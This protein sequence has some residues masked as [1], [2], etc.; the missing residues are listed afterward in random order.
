MIGG[1]SIAILAAGQASRFGGGK[2][3][4][5]LN[6]RPLG[7]WAVD[8]ALALPAGQVEIVVAEPVPLFARQAVSDGV[9]GLILNHRAGDGL[10]TSVALAARRAAEIEANVLLLMLADM[11]LVGTATL[12]RLM[13]EA[14][15]GRPAALRHLSGQAGIPAC[16]TSD[17]FPAL[18]S[19]SGDRGAAALLRDNEATVR[20]DVDPDE[21]QDVDTPADLRRLS[22]RN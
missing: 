13:A 17:F 9:A 6:G 14:A 15:P 10:S 19:L 2:L 22:D 7:R 12:R 20:I 18:E 1:L 11:P 16:F 4:A 5:P 3:D 8:A 21:L